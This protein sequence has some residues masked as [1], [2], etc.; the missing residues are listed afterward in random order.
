MRGR[1]V[2]TEIYWS[3]AHR[4]KYLIAN[5]IDLQHGGRTLTELGVQH[6]PELEGGRDQH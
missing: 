5:I 3:A 1:Y 2:G 4:V 6:R